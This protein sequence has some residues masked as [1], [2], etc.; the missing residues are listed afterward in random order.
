MHCV[1]KHS[2]FLPPPKAL[3]EQSNYFSS[4]LLGT[5]IN[6][7]KRDEAKQTFTNRTQ[8]C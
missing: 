5:Q 1:V 8:Q 2:G 3:K 6:L 7:S 4:L